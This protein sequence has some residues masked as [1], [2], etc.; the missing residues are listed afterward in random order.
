VTQRHHAAQPCTH[1]R[2]AGEPAATG[3]E[4]E[5]SRSES[6]VSLVY[7]PRALLPAYLPG[8]LRA[9]C[10]GSM[11]VRS[12]QV[13]MTTAP[14]GMGPLTSS[15]TSRLTYTVLPSCLVAGRPLARPPRPQE[16][17]VRGAGRSRHN[18]WR[19]HMPRSFHGG[20]Q[21]ATP[22][23]ERPRRIAFSSSSSATCV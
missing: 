5:P 17:T 10:D 8:A 21:V 20:D 1:W 4:P 23:G 14:S 11:Q 2:A 18:S 7:L 15:H 19:Q 16:V 13:E 6:S 9:K 3:A 22:C 12:P